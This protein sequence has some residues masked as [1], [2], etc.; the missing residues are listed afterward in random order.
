MKK[1]Y[2]LPLFLS[3]GVSSI[4]LG[5]FN[6]DEE[7]QKRSYPNQIPSQ[8]DHQRRTGSNPHRISNHNVPSYQESS[9]FEWGSSDKKK[10]KEQESQIVSLSQSI[11]QLG[12]DV[13]RFRSE[14]EKI[15]QQ[16]KLLEAEKKS[17]EVRFYEKSKIC[18]E[19]SSLYNQSLNTYDRDKKSWEED[20][21]YL[22]GN[23]SKASEQIK[24]LIY[25]KKSL[26]HE[27]SQIKEKLDFSDSNLQ[28]R[29]RSIEELENILSLKQIEF[30][31]ILH[32][33]N[34]LE[35]EVHLLRQHSTK[36]E[37]DLIHTRKMGAAGLESLKTH[38]KKEKE[39]RDFQIE[40][41]FSELEDL[42]KRSIVF[43][44]E[45][46]LLRFQK[47]ELENKMKEIVEEKSSLSSV[48]Q[49]T[50]VFQKTID[51]VQ[52]KNQGLEKLLIK[53]KSDYEE[54][55]MNLKQ[56]LMLKQA[57]SLH[58][59]VNEKGG[60]LDIKLRSFIPEFF[61]KLFT[62]AGV[63]DGKIEDYI[64]ELMNEKLGLLELLQKAE[65]FTK[66]E[67]I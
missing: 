19:L 57:D 11:H 54:Q 9:L 2:F 37:G 17:L 35:S 62:K 27:I 50:S 59:N 30:N 16:K 8:Q 38:L 4:A 33:R 6:E 66:K 42:R 14:L 60:K 34:E 10:I 47:Q 7:A 26:E 63:E 22:E 32:Q 44:K 65:D 25:E 52:E 64:M 45:N 36:L 67:N 43:E 1:T 61:M 55:I 40:S 46:D 48:S 20:K 21:L 29:Q 39:S 56:S 49:N 5:S 58:I 12:E 23:L 31:D 3:L 18:E 13:F 53:Q 51:E 24:K 15:S 28:T 41:Y